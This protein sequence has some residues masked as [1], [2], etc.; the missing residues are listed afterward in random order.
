LKRNELE[1]AQAKLR[2]REERHQF[3]TAQLTERRDLQRK[4]QTLKANHQ[5][6]MR[7]LF[8]DID[9]FTMPRDLDTRVP[10]LDR[11][12]NRN[13]GSQP[14]PIRPRGLDLER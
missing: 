6:R 1:A 10:Q 14:K 13:A 12:F 3:I 7:D 8:K 11:A 9:R 5:D 2:D 4:L